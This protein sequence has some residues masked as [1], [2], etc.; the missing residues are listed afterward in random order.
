MSQ[1][2]L[3]MG[4]EVEMLDPDLRSLWRALQMGISLNGKLD[5]HWATGEKMPPIEKVILLLRVRF[6]IMLKTRRRSLKIFYL[7]SKKK[8]FF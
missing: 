7:F 1:H 2:F 8:V 4:C 6:S 3:E 5:I